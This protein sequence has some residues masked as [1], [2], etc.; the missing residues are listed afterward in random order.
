MANFLF[1]VNYTRPVVILG[2]LKDRIN[3]DLLS[4][5]PDRYGSCVPHTSRPQ[6]DHEVDGRDYHFVTKEQMETD[7]ANH[8]FIE[9]GQYNHNLYGTSVESVRKVAEQVRRI[10]LF[11]IFYGLVFIFREGIVFWTS[12]EML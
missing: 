2:A 10:F 11:F 7:I 8:M 4:E 9:A 3:D 1:S 6:R 5:F 12:A